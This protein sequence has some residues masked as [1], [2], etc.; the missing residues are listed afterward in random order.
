MRYLDRDGTDCQTMVNVA[1][2]ESLL[3]NL[4]GVLDD[5]KLTEGW[6]LETTDGVKLD[7][8]ASANFYKEVRV[9]RNVEEKD[10]FLVPRPPGGRRGRRLFTSWSGDLPVSIARRGEEKLLEEERMS[11]DGE[12]EQ[13]QEMRY[14]EEI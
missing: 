6:I 1:G 10:A 13:E 9:F 7:H 3:S 11:G 8:R 2:N 12:V 4:P 14:D 5:L